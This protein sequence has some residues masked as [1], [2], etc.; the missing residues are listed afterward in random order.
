MGT[1]TAAS[2]GT[3]DVTNKTVE[4]IKK[5]TDA[6]NKATAEINA[7]IAAVDALIAAIV[8]YQIALNE[9]K[10]RDKILNKMKIPNPDEVDGTFKPKFPLGDPWSDLLRHPKGT[11]PLLDPSRGD[12]E[13]G[14]SN[15]FVTRDQDTDP[16]PAEDK[17]VLVTKLIIKNT[18]DGVIDPSPVLNTQNRGTGL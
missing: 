11:K 6:I 7:L 9:L 18:H 4:D 1:G 3:P 16:N 15:I 2:D 12:I 17:N 5:D 14:A 10:I 8:R 13:F